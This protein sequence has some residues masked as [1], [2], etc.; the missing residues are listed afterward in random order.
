MSEAKGIKESLEVLEGFKVVAVPVKAALKDGFQ[1][2]DFGQ[3]L[4]IIEQYKV[5]VEAVDGAADVI[6]E[7]KDLDPVEASAI[8]A[9]VFEVIK[10]IKE[11]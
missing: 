1:P 5:I 2:S 6:G 11:A 4:K 9:K 7:A 10:A 3:A 8:A